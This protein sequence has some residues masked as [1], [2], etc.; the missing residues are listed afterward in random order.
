MNNIKNN[1]KNIISKIKNNII[2]IKNKVFKKKE[3]NVNNIE[4][5]NQISTTENNIQNDSIETNNEITIEGSDENMGKKKSN[6]EKNNKKDKQKEV[7]LNKKGKPKKTKKQIIQIIVNIILIMCNLFAIFGL[8]F[9][10]WFA[11]Y[12]VKKAP[13]VDP[14]KLLYSESSLIYAGDLLLD[15]L[16][17]E[18][19]DL[20]EY[21]DLPQI[22]IDAIVAT[23]DSE[24]Y[25]HT[26][27]NMARFA[28]ASVG[29]ILGKIS[30]GSS[31]AGG[32]STI[33]MQVIKNNFTD[34][35]S[36]GWDGI[37]RKF[38]DIYLAVFKIEK[39]Y[40]KE[41]I[42]EFYVNKPFLGSN[43]Y[44]IEQ[45]A[46]TYFGKSISEVSLPEA[47]L[48]AGLF[49]APGSY[50]PYL[51]PEAAKKRRDTVL[52]LMQRHG[53]ITK[54]EAEAA[55]KV[56]IESMLV[57]KNKSTNKYAAFIDTAIEEVIKKTGQDPRTTPMI[58]YTTMNQSKQDHINCVTDGGCYNFKNDV[59]QTAIA[60]V[61]VNAGAIVAIGAGRNRN[62]GDLNLAT[63]SL[64]QIGSNAKPLF[65]YG[66]AIEYNKW[67]TYQP[68]LDAP[69]SYSNGRSIKNDDGGYLGLLTLKEALGRSRNIPALK[70][71]QSVNNESIYKFVTS[72][73]I[74]PETESG[75][76][77]VHEAH[78]IG[79]FTGSNPLQLAAAYAA[80]A[81]GGYY[82]E[83]Y[84]VSKI[85][86]RDT[87]E[88][89]EF[90]PKKT[91]VMEDYTAFM[92]TDILKWSA[93]YGMSRSAAHI[94]GI[95]IAAKT[96]TTNYDSEFERKNGL[97]NAI[98][99]LW[100]TGYSPD[101][102][103]SM[104]YGLKDFDKDYYSTTD[105][106]NTRASLYQA[107]IRGIFE[108]NGH[109]FTVPNSVV[110]IGV[111]KETVP[112]MLPSEYTP[113]DMIVYEYF[114]RGTEP[115]EVS[116]RFSKLNDVTN[117]NTSV[118]NNKVKLTWKYNKPNH[119]TDDYL[120][121]YY[122]NSVFK[123]NEETYFNK[124]KE[125]DSWRLGNIVFNVYLK[126]TDGTLKLLG[127]TADTQY[128]YALS[129]T[130]DQLEFVVKTTYTVLTNNL[131]NG[132]SIK[133]SVKDLIKPV[134][135]MSLSGKKEITIYTGS[136]YT[137]PAKAPVIVMDSLVDITKD[138]VIKT[139]ITKDGKSYASSA[140]DTTAPAK[141]IITYTATY[142]GVSDS[143]TQTIIVAKKA[144]VT[145]TP[146]SSTSNSSSSTS[147]S[148]TS[149]SQSSSSSSTSSS[150]N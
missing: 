105:D 63:Q 119:L 5:I 111:E 64:K 43:S 25:Q 141:Y 93:D 24:Y 95:D 10:V 98:N 110:K 127:Q 61:D 106:W 72:L 75:S 133:I 48:L 92:V 60:V 19:R 125:E 68:V 11:N 21:N 129:R 71:F 103:V 131:S 69:Y 4:N 6:K 27:D 49:K 33:T 101:Y 65:D 30:S 121:N 12:I 67:S 102:A 16:G 20:V 3:T 82:I 78:A 34:K 70:T 74:T 46:K 150:K 128:T 112:A 139:S 58:I 89:V 147:S 22:L 114:I 148:N 140:I 23:E 116:P 86:Y 81:N 26:G 88:T 1:I 107:I 54:E 32:A 7:I 136:T 96:G 40:T 104:W 28:K 90:S 120:R 62:K 130:D 9:L 83:P 124:R 100:V 55:K 97:V 37:V 143:I 145:P 38:T 35:V 36:S 50:D 115:T 76:T 138:A 126:Q 57:G 118:E 44:G 87:N 2:N 13:D 85:V 123:G 66:P 29:Q 91:K 134:L 39:K 42:L 122:N 52:Y 137:L 79:A 45:A 77:N 51:H 73:G 117:L 99:D 146:S 8:I 59:V 56:S 80:F 149:S 108:Y 84:S 31:D 109:S 142:K 17:N 113:D 47:A 41:E 132:S 18:K 53:Y 144:D 135:T 14:K 94:N 15:E